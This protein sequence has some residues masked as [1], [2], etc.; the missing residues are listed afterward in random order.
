VYGDGA[1]RDVLNHPNMELNVADC[2]NMQAVI[3][4]VKGADAIIHLAAIVGDP[5]CDLDHTTALEINYAST[6]MLIEVAKGHGVQ[7]LVFASSCSVYGATEKHMDET[8]E[9]VPLSLYGKTKLDSEEAL[10]HARDEAFHPVIARLATVFGNSPRPRFDLVVNLLTAKAHSEGVITIYNG[11]Q[12][13]PF[14]HVDDVARGFVTLL[15]A[16]LQ[17][18][19]GEIFNLGDTRLNFR[20]SDVATRIREHFPNTTITRVDNSYRRNYRVSFDKIRTRIAFQC[21]MTLDDGILELKQAFNSGAITEYTNELY[22]NQK[23]L[24]SRGTPT[25]RTPMDAEVMAAFASQGGRELHR[26]VHV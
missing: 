19:S 18:V 25:A 10:L 5:A 1:I 23:Y 26:I 6:R 16:P 14:I 24:Q 20:L 21:T 8:C 4:A 7:R 13:R 3:A 12:W 22:S 17:S 11:E 9:T 2:R 15:E